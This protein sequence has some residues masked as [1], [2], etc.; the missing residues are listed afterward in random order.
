M[1][2]QTTALHESQIRLQGRE[3]TS[4]LRSSALSASTHATAHAAS[5]LGG[6]HASSPSSAP[7][8][9]NRSPNSPTTHAHVQ[10][11]RSEAAGSRCA[12]RWRSA[13]RAAYAC[14]PSSAFV[15]LTMNAH[16]TCSCMRAPLGRVAHVPSTCHPQQLAWRIDD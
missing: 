14:A 6:S 16:E 4:A 13:A 9:T 15:T 7:A 2:Q 8:P 5:P 11:R 10:R 1:R 12:A 3:R